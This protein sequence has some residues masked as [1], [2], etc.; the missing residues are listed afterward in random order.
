[1]IESLLVGAVHAAL[2]LALAGLGEL[3]VQRAGVVNIGIEGIMLS[4]ALCAMICTFHTGSPALGLIAACLLGIVLA[5]GFGALTVWGRAD[6]IVTGVALNLLAL[7]GTGVWY[8]AAFGQTGQALTVATMERISIPGLSQIA[9]IGPMLF[10]QP[11]VW[12]LVMVLCVGVHAFLYR[13]RA[14]LA[15]RAAGENPGAVEA[16]GLSVLKIRFMAVLWGGLMA[17]CAGACLSL[18]LSNTFIEGMSSGRGFV[19]LALV[20]FG[21]WT[22]WGVLGAALF[23]GGVWALQFRLQAAGWTDAYQLFLMSPYL[24][25]LMALVLAKGHSAAPA[26]L[27]KSYKRSA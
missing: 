18:F 20:I 13:T 16:S 10:S 21:R 27:G 5:A 26:V 14:G 12:Y 3:V 22:P 11:A 25:T 9:Y 1:M 17:G 23:F 6:Q 19:V 4:G 7:G 15:L 24:L 8:R 2:P